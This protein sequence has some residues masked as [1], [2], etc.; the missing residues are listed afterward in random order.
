MGASGLI[1]HASCVA[2]AGRAVLIVGP[3]GSGK[4]ALA[5]QLIALGADLVADDRTDLSRHGND[6]VAKSPPSIAGLI[7]ARGVGILSRR[8]LAQA[9]V[10]LAVDLSRIATARLPAPH[11]MTWL[12][13][14]VPCLHK[15]D[16]AYF[17]AAVHAYLTGNR[18]EIS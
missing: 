7:E 16:A 4:S 1:V 6:L 9:P 18:T 12:D 3:S 13:M 10:A 17:P 15:V 14:Q 8:H 11:T 5:L 2:V